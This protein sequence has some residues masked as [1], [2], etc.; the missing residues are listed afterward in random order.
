MTMMKNPIVDQGQILRVNPIMN[1]RGDDLMSQEIT[2][3]S[4][5]V[6]DNKRDNKCDNKRDNITADP[7]ALLTAF[8]EDL[9][10]LNVYYADTLLKGASYELQ[11]NTFV[12]YPADASL[13]AQIKDILEAPLSLIVKQKYNKSVEIVMRE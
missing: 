13:A 12:I 2:A 6:N 10:R 9:R 1:N 7:C 3:M 8:Q 11:D 4:K 5:S